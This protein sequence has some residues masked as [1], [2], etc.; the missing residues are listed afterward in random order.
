MIDSDGNYIIK[1]KSFKNFNFFEFYK[2]YNPADFSRI[3]E[4]KSRVHTVGIFK[5]KNSKGK[6]CLIVHVPVNF[7]SDW[8][9]ISYIYLQN[10][11]RKMR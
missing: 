6:D 4:L 11:L 5:M 8:S 2:S 3:E 7:A 1:G 10:I 9:I